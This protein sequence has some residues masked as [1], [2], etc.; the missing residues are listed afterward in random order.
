MLCP[1]TGHD[2]VY[3]KVDQMNSRQRRADRKKWRYEVTI[4]AVKS[5][6]DYDAMFDWCVANY[7]NTCGISSNGWREKHGYIGTCWQFNDSA[8]AAAFALR[9]K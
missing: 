8:K 6:K 2:D 9:W 4:N 1:G 5:S 7:G 3:I